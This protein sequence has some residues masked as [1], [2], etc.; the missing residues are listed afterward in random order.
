VG[1]SGWTY[2]RSLLL[3]GH[4]YPTLA[5]VGQP[6]APEGFSLALP[7]FLAHLAANATHSFVGRFGALWLALPRPWTLLVSAGLLACLVIAVARP[8]RPGVRLLQLPVLTVAVMFVT[9]ALLVHL[10]TGAYAAQ[11]GRYLFPVAA[12]LGVAVAS[13]LAGVGPR[14]AAVLVMG[15][16]G[17]GWLLSAWTLMTGFWAGGG[18]AGRLASIAS[19]SPIGGMGVLLLV[20]A[21]ACFWLAL[22][23]AARTGARLARA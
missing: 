13:A 16:A 15:T 6:V 22:L 14:W 1:A 20:C 23:L 21:T 5:P 4:P 19:W 9:T 8:A 7:S 11:Q 17:V 18:V 3:H 2:L 10:E 12:S